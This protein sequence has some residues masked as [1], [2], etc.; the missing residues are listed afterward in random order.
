MFTGLGTKSLATIYVALIV[1]CMFLPSLVIK[2]LTCK[3]AMV[4]CTF[5]YSLYMVAQF[6][7]TSY[8]LIPAAIVLGFGA[9]PMWSAKCTYLTQVS[10]TEERLQL[11]FSVMLTLCVI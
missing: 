4:A 8:T 7:P 3:W 11:L 1:S 10:L 6:Y 5:C 2:K 9:A